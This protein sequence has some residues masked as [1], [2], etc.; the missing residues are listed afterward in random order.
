MRK[1]LIHQVCGRLGHP[2]AATGGAKSALLAREREQFLFV[3]I[4]AAESKEA[5]RQNPATQEAFKFLRDV[6]GKALSLQLRQRLEGSIVGGN[7]LIQYR[8]FRPARQV[9]R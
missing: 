3:A 7:G 5:I 6:L 9:R 1:D 4:V 8:F 2:P